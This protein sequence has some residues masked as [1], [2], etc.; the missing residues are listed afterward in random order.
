MKNVIVPLADKYGLQLFVE[1][2]RAGK[3]ATLIIEA[4]RVKG[5][6]AE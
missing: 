5:E 3:E 6:G 1:D 4:G 2:C